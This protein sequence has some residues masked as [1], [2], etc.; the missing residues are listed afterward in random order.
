MARFSIELPEDLKAK[1]E[2]RAAESG[3]QSVEDYLTSLIRAD[4]NGAAADYGAAHG[5]TFHSQDQLEAMLSEGL[6]SPA[7]EMSTDD[8]A[9]LRRRALNR[10]PE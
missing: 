2:V 1:A 3:H 4:A 5:L 9:D 8:W 7:S 6:A 10:Q